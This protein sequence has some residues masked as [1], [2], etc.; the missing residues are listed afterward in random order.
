M[1]R[2]I[3][4]MEIPTFKAK[5]KKA[6]AETLLTIADVAARLN[7]HT[8]SV[9]RLLASGAL[10]SISVGHCRRI[11]PDALRSFIATRK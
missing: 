1:K 3:A 10:P 2:L 7:V 8:R 11:H 4:P 5:S 9:S 6:P